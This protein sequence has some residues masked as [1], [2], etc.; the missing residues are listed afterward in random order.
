MFED[1]VEMVGNHVFYV[2][3]NYSRRDSSYINAFIKSVNDDTE[4]NIHPRVFKERK[5]RIQPKVVAE[6]YVPLSVT[7]NDDGTFRLS[8]KMFKYPKDVDGN[9]LYLR[10]IGNGVCGF[11]SIPSEVIERIFSDAGLEELSGTHTF[12]VIWKSSEYKGRTRIFSSIGAIDDDFETN[13][14]YFKSR[15]VY[16]NKKAQEETTIPESE[17]VA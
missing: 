17:T 1:D 5:P 3:W 13:L 12:N 11:P 15:K 9:Q 16:K 8:S 14:E 2:E 7:Q 10:K 6:I 4:P